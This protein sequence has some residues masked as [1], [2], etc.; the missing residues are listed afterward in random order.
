[1]PSNGGP[2]CIRIQESNTNLI[3]P[4]QSDW[5]LFNV[6]SHVIPADFPNSFI[7]KLTL[8]ECSKDKISHVDSLQDQITLVS[9]ETLYYSTDYNSQLGCYLFIDCVSTHIENVDI[10]KCEK[11]VF[12]FVSS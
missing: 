10:L 12:R 6:S 5:L 7:S 9:F 11:L 3:D 4:M 1:M 2:S 8:L